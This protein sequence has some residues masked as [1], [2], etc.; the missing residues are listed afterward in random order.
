MQEA[1]GVEWA[2]AHYYGKQCS[3]NLNFLEK[4]TR[5]KKNIQKEKEKKEGCIEMQYY[6][7]QKIRGAR[8]SH[9][10][11]RRPKSCFV[12]VESGLEMKTKKLQG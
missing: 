11:I 3:I 12:E 9:G 2:T 4:E 8:T 5:Q 1:K 7:Y 10:Q 6:P